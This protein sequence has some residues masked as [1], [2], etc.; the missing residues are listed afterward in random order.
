M[1]NGLCPHCNESVSVKTKPTTESIMT[2]SVINGHVGKH[3]WNNFN[4]LIVIT[5]MIW[6][7]E[8]PH[9]MRQSNFQVHLFVTLLKVRGKVV[10]KLNIVNWQLYES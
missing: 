1:D 9:S 7:Q 5:D 8:S 3:L 4:L 2:L 10:D 6:W